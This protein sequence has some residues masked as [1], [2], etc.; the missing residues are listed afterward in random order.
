MA[1]ARIFVRGFLRACLLGKLD[2][3]LARVEMSCKAE[4]V[5]GHGGQIGVESESGKGS[6]F[7]FTIPIAKESRTKGEAR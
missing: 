2:P 7:W 4:I 5:R 3:N 1:D 6:S